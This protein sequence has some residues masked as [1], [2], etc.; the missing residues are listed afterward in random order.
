MRLRKTHHINYTLDALMQNDN[1]VFE[2]QLIDIIARVQLRS[3]L[4]KAIDQL[5]V[6]NRC[7]YMMRAVQQLSTC[8][9]ALSL[10]VTE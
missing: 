6:G 7:V 3:L 8:E 9:T 1:P 5:L 2:V 4:E 10:D